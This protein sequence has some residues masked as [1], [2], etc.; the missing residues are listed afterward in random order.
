[1]PMWLRHALRDGVAR[2]IDRLLE[3]DRERIDPGGEVTS[4]VGHGPSLLRWGRDRQ[5]T[6]QQA[7]GHADHQGQRGS[8]DDAPAATASRDVE[9]HQRCAGNATFA[10]AVVIASAP[11]GSRH[12]GRRR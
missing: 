8:N 10:G 5:A 2:A 9:R 1:M 3:L 12:P 6:D 7:G 4:A 11:R